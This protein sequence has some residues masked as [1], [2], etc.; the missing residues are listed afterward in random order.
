MDVNHQYR[1]DIVLNYNPIRHNI[2]NRNGYYYYYYFCYTVLFFRSPKTATALVVAE[3]E[4]A[5]AAA[6][7][8]ISNNFLIESLKFLCTWQKIKKLKNE[9]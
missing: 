6:T 2:K 1:S 7:I 3:V 5:K 9:K 8:S 4:A